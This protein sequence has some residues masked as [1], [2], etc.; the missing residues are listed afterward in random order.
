MASFSGLIAGAKNA[1]TSP[2]LGARQSLT[3]NATYGMMNVQSQIN[4][5]I[6]RASS[7]A[8]N[9]LRSAAMSA[10]TGDF[11]GAQSKLLGI[12]NDMTKASFGS[13]PSFA[14][15]AQGQ[16]NPGNPFQ[17]I[18]A[19]Q[20]ALLNFNWFCMPPL[21]P[22][23]TL[24][25]YYVEAGTLPFRVIE[26]QDVYRRGHFE[27]IPKTYSVS[28]LQLTFFLDNSMQTMMYLKRWQD[29]VL[30]YGKAADYA[31]QGKWG[32]PHAPGD[33]G[34]YRNIPVSIL[35]VNRQEVM[36]ITYYD[37]WPTNIDSLQVVSDASGRLMATVDF[38]TND[39]DIDVMSASSSSGLQSAMQSK[40]PNGLMGFGLNT[41][42]KVGSALSSIPSKVSN[43]FQPKP[44]E[45]TGGYF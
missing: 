34:F 38:A 35:S 2:V 14:S 32:R 19:R 15:L 40:S 39:V 36:T 29:L 25:W 4:G 3:N 28:G 45:G 1:A 10:L 18:N 6:N 44:A 21:L 13:D 17:G 41:L 33:M 22:G 9:G 23:V 42:S 7:S 16:A 5:G 43:F 37:A 12:P 31:N 11:S 27:K 8:V 20:D 24:P 30:R 26:T